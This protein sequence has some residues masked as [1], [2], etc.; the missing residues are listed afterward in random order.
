[1][2]PCKELVQITNSQDLVLI[3][4]KSQVLATVT[5]L[6]DSP[7]TMGQLQVAGIRKIKQA[8]KTEEHKR[9]T[10]GEPKGRIMRAHTAK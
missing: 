2:S 3:C 9:T 1:M 4:A 5:T 6:T 7:E 8:Q 10:R